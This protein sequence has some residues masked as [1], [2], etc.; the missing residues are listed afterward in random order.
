[1]EFGRKLL[2]QKYS[3]EK[4]GRS[5][6]G[7][8][9]AVQWLRLCASNAEG[10]VLISSQRSYMPHS[11][12]RG[13]RANDTSCPSLT[14]VA[15]CLSPFQPESLSHFC[16]P[17]SPFTPFV[18]TDSHWQTHPFFALIL[19]YPKHVPQALSFWHWES[20]RLGRRW[21]LW[22]ESVDQ[23]FLTGEVDVG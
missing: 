18:L 3:T 20:W 10:M 4:L 14:A 1:M 21:P 15:F 16:L 2:D 11:A 23:M 8:S 22:E 9:L 17:I 13:M 19:K 5:C 7:T 6:F 12:V